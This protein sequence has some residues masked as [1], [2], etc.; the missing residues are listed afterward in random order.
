MTKPEALVFLNGIVPE[1]VTMIRVDA[2]KWDE[3]KT[4]VLAL[5]SDPTLDPKYKAA[6]ENV[7]ATVDAALG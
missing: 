2:A 4:L 5:L 7:N 1:P 6:L 3:F